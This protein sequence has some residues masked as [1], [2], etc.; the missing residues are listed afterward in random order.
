MIDIDQ[1]RI[2]RDIET[3]TSRGF[4]FVHFKTR[5]AMEQAL[6]GN[7][8]LR[9]SQCKISQSSQKKSLLFV[10]NL[11]YAMSSDQV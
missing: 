8:T 4:G 10:G 6:N 11:P 3:G 5:A 9:G 1:T 2:F 7:I